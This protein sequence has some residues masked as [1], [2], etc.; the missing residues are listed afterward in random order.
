MPKQRIPKSTVRARMAA[1]GETYQ[2]ALSGLQRQ[3]PQSW[4]QP[5][6]DSSSCV[7]RCRSVY[8]ANDAAGHDAGSMTRCAYCPGAVCVECGK[9][10]VTQE[11][12]VCPPCTQ[13]KQRLERDALLAERCAGMECISRAKAAPAHYDY[14]DSDMVTCK[15]CGEPICFCG[16]PRLD[17]EAM[18]GGCYPYDDDGSWWE[19][20]EIPQRRATLRYLAAVIKKLGGGSYAEVY[21]C[22]AA[23]MGARIGHANLEQLGDGLEHA[24]EWKRRLRHGD[25]TPPPV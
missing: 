2:Q 20:E 4:L 23:A 1:T 11:F 21:A 14:S 17:Y 19:A 7:G 5:P 22:L 8:L 6:E 25:R 13:A 9:A 24:W 18:C 16:R 10:A 12:E 3:V 15:P